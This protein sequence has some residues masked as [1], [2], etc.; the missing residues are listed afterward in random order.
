MERHAEDLD[1]G[2][3]SQEAAEVRCQ[4]VSSAGAG[5]DGS[6]CREAED[7]RH[8]AGKGRLPAA[9]GVDLQGIRVQCREVGG[10]LF[11]IH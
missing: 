7:G 2:T 10:D 1:Q 6:L 8:R 3:I 4:G 11:V 9:Q 5:R